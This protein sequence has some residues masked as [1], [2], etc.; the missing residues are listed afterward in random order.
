[1]DISVEIMDNFFLI[2]L[3]S[4]KNRWRCFLHRSGSLQAVISSRA[5]SAEQQAEPVGG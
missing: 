5:K 1:V 4:S 2:Q 3:P